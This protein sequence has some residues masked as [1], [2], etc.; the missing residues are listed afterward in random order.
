ML[1][2]RIITSEHYGC[3]SQEGGPSPGVSVATKPG[4]FVAKQSILMREKKKK[5]KS[6]KETFV[7]NL[8]AVLTFI[9]ATRLSEPRHPNTKPHTEIF[10]TSPPREWN[11]KHVSHFALQ[12]IDWIIHRRA[13]KKRQDDF[14]TVRNASFNNKS[15]VERQLCPSTNTNAYARSFCW[16]LWLHHIW[17]VF[18]FYPRR[19]KHCL[20]LY[21]SPAWDAF[22][23]NLLWLFIQWNGM[24][25]K[26][27]P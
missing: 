26:I 22:N 5:R 9:P 1:R 21:Y 12:W 23:L 11:K 6:S 14:M 7:L 18:A 19:S 2:Y 3:I 24:K 20:Y 16:S 13:N 10:L 4:M 15:R 27:P 25:W 17:Y 8:S